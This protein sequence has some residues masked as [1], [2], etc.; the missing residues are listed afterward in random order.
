MKRA[1]LFLFN[2][3]LLSAT[4]F[5]GIT[6]SISGTVTDPSGGV[7]AGASVTALNVETG[8]QS[9]TK[10]NAEGFYSFPNLPIGR[11][12]I[13]VRATGFAELQETNLVLD[14]NAALRLDA[15]LKVATATEKVVI[16]ATA[17]QVDT[18]STQM[19]ELIGRK[20]MV[21][22]PLNGRDW[23][24]LMALQ[25]GVAPQDYV[26]QAGTGYSPGTSEGKY[27]ISG[28]R[29]NANG[30]MVNGANVEEPMLNGVSTV[31]NLDSIAEFR[32]LTSNFDAEYGHYSGG[33]VNLVTKSGTNNFHGDAFEFLRFTGLN[34][35]NYYNPASLGPKS[36]YIHNQFG[37][38]F[39]GPMRSDK[40]FFFADYEG[41][42][43]TTGGG[44]SVTPVP[45]LADTQGNL[46]DQ[47][48]SLTG[49]VTGPAFANTLS[50]QLRYPVNVGEAFYFANCASTDPST[51]C[52]FPHAVI[53]KAAFNQVSA[54]LL[55]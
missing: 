18:Q 31:P 45:S 7:V 47:A 34:A 46:I 53:P 2:L 54:N 51:G 21:T 5:A 27:S 10:T 6:G 26:T 4:A 30:F 52:V 36:K 29:E 42:R 33:M 35:R 24:E 28:G 40:L 32:I 37:G 1:F 3:L 39:G 48:G 12:S 55:K 14:V 8:V 15:K 9:S 17:A 20:E 23:T 13:Q 11:Y 22:L 16:S 50:T 38:T 19:G 44:S 43:R 41:L 25:P 49:S